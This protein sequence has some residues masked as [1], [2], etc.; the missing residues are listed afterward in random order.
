MKKLLT[1]LLSMAM[2]IAG[3]AAS[4]FADSPVL[5]EQEKTDLGSADIAL[6]ATKAS[7]YTVKLPKKLDVS[8]DETTFA[9]E[10]LGDVDGDYELAF[11]E[12][13]AGS[14][15][16]T[17]LSGRI[18]ALTLTVTVGDPIAGK[19]IGA[20]YNSEKASS[21]KI[22]HAGIKAGTWQG[23]LPIIIKLQKV[24]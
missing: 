9:I 14:N 2:I 5:E 4:V 15:V 23:T 16:L 24:A 19:D 7:T 21:M 13:N 18:D 10:A 22:E 8:S 3:P 20:T 11:E 6:T 12:S 1:V 17:D